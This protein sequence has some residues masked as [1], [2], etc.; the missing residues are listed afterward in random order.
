VALP[1]AFEEQENKILL[2]IASGV[3]QHT[4]KLKNPTR[5]IDFQS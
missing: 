4:P 1:R 2:E 3:R 5:K